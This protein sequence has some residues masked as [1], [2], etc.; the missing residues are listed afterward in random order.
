MLSRFAIYF[1]EV[2]R[3]GSI[4]R[5]SEHL[6]I[7][8]SAIDRQILQM[9]EQLGVPLFERTP[10]GLRLTSAGELM[11]VAIRRWRRDLRK[12]EAQIDELRGLRRGEVDIALVEGGSDFVIRSLKQFSERYPGIVLRL[13]LSAS[14]AVVE[15]VMKGE[16]DLGIA[17]NPPDRQEIRI[18]SLLGC[19][20]G[21]VM[22]PDHPLAQRPTLTLAECASHA[23]VGPDDSHVLRG[24]FDRAWAA[25]VGGSP[26]FV[27]TA[28]SIGL[29]KSLVLNGAGLGFLTP[30]DV[31]NEVEQGQLRYRPL[32]ASRLPPSVLSLITA[33]GRSLSTA[34]SLMHQHLTTAM[35]REQPQGA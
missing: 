33:S 11:I 32:N 31:A 29:V 4:R 26:R 18:G 6:N 30:I 19:Q 3:R 34:A 14:E 16:A 7:T 10:Q 25:N 24:L 23:M 1:D 28:S 2:A 15:R 13:H 20:L 27:A 8:A 22:L 17:F 9:E 21:A 35:L 12:L 5:A